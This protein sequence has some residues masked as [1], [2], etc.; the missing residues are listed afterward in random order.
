MTIDTV[1][2]SDRI[3]SDPEARQLL[4]HLQNSLDNKKIHSAVL[5]YDF[6]SY[7]DYEGET[8]KP[9]ILVL[10]SVGVIF[11]INVFSK[12]G[13]F[14]SEN[15][16]MRAVDDSVS[17]FCSNLVGRLLKSRELRVNRSSLKIIVCPVIF[18]PSGIADD[19]TESEIITSY[20]GL[21]ALIHSECTGENSKLE[22]SEAR[23]VIEGAKALA[24]PKKREV[25]DPN[26]DILALALS[27]LEGEIANFDEKQ[28]ITALST[29]PG[30]QRIR[31][32]AGSGKTVILAMKA[33]HL[34]MSNPDAKILVT[35]YTKSLRSS[36]SQLI[37]RFY[38]HYKDEDPNWTNIH[39]RHGWGGQNVAG[40]YSD[41]CRRH[42]I[43]P[44]NF[45]TASSKGREPFDVVCRDLVSRTTIK[46][47]YDY[48]LID[49]GQ[50]FP[51]GFYE[52][53][54][55]LA[56]GGR[57]QKNIVWA[58]DEL[59]NILNVKIRT[60]EE[61]FGIDDN[62]PKISLERAAR[63]LPAGV[64]ND[65]VLSK[66]YRNQGKVLVTAHAAGFGIYSNQIVQLLQDGEHWQDV[67]YKVLSGDFT[68]GS[69]VVLERPIENS[70]LTLDEAICGP[71]IN[72]FIARTMSKE[73]EWVCE[74]IADQLSKG[75]KPED[76]M[77]ISLDNRNARTYLKNI[78]RELVIRG[79]E[80]NNILADPYNEPPFCIEGKVTLSTVYR[81]KGNEAASVYALGV[82]A[83]DRKWRPARN[84]LFAAFTRSKAW[85]HVSGVGGN[86]VAIVEEINRAVQSYPKLEF[87][88]PDLGHVD[89]IQRDLSDRNIRAKRL[90]NE[91]ID[92][93]QSEGFSDDE[94]T[95]LLHVEVKDEQD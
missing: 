21:D 33:A 34:H 92:R 22:F 69:R 42:S 67:G 25:T 57:D 26:K 79:I 52:M 41:T 39:V 83:I 87:K 11:A 47:F 94:I 64:V 9:D 59:Q 7:T 50:D 75:L 55:L 91:F 48:I 86:V 73:V 61:L 17:Q 72:T 89:L 93:L 20:E 45:K 10:T 40:V 37:T 77:V 31:G 8:H 15:H 6:P 82:D 24:R 62:E 63:N 29:I 43:V 2:T 16:S 38:R 36:I 84:M 88:M 90:R 81:A 28:R 66:C 3:N 54:F 27:K 56:K 60:P 13:L 53:C 74:K 12:G 78:S 35:Y 4:E 68:V 58:Y 44:M 80:S 14:R 70:P 32:L 71:T 30:P 76:I 23:S 5:Y 19:E 49:E 1:V 85:L 51:S 65:V 95:D 46:P 18:S